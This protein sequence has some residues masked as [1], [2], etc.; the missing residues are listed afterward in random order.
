MAPACGSCSRNRSSTESRLMLWM[1]SIC[2][3]ARDSSASS[4]ERT[5]RGSLGCTAMSASHMESLARTMPVSV[6]SSSCVLGR[7]RR[8]R[9][10][11]GLKVPATHAALV[12]HSLRTDSR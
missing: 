9:M 6:S 8:R 3:R 7:L 11:T 5:S 2:V 10:F 12:S 1:R 4:P